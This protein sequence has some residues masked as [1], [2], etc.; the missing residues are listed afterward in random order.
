MPVEFPQITTRG[1][2]G[3]ST[4]LYNGERRRKSDFLFEVLGDLDELSSTLGLS[5]ALLVEQWSGQVS[6]G[7]LAER[8]ERIQEALVPIGG[9]VATPPSASRPAPALD[10]AILE[11]LEHWQVEYMDGLV[12]RRF[13]QPGACS[14]SAALDMARTVARR[15][16]RHLVRHIDES[17]AVGF[18][19]PSRY[20]NRLSDFL[21]VAARYV[22]RTIG[23]PDT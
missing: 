21:F 9:Q 4:S 20:L 17:Y 3:G 6:F 1:G 19:L 13:V 18:E 8:L 5:R 10:P 22:A 16:E 12:M 7:V 11:T 14:A 2:D 15:A 23:R